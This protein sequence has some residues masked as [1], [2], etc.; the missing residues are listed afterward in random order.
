MNNNYDLFS[1]FIFTIGSILFVYLIVPL[2]SPFFLFIALVL[3]PGWLL[4]EI[5]FFDFKKLNLILQIILLYFIGSVFIAIELWI[6]ILLQVEIN[7][8]SLVIFGV[9]ISCALQL[10]LFIKR[11]I[12]KK[13]VID[14]HLLVN[15]KSLTISVG[16]AIVI[17]FLVWY[18]IPIDQEA[19]TEF[20]VDNESP[21][22]SSYYKGNLFIINHEKDFETYSI[23]C[24]DNS[25]ISINIIQIPSQPEFDNRNPISG[26]RPRF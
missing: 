13:M 17:G 12:N 9:S 20:Y 6:L 4:N 26:S 5:I 3:L 15:L 11:K 19:Y 23:I 16:L 24:T 25:G 2:I 18:S 22:L 14:N 10:F 7:S 21:V 1:C 8:K